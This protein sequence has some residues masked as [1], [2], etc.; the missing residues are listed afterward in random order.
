MFHKSCIE[1]TR[2]GFVLLFLFLAKVRT[3]NCSDNTCSF[4]LGKSPFRPWSHKEKRRSEMPRDRRHQRP[5]TNRSAKGSRPP[6]PREKRS[7][8]H[9]D[10]AQYGTH[11]SSEHHEV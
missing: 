2:S 1:V 9:D 7:M 5:R 8:K 6:R 10:M 4:Y 11:E 3:P